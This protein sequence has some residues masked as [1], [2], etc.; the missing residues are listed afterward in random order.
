MT[1][2]ATVDLWQGYRPLPAREIRAG[3]AGIARIATEARGRETPEVIADLRATLARTLWRQARWTGRR[4]PGLTAELLARA[5]R[6][7]VA[8]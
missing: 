4:N 2:A 6:W 3:L 1:S 8:A 5:A 7:K